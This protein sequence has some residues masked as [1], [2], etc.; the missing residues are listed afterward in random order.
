[1]RLKLRI[2][3]G[4]YSIARATAGSKTCSRTS[5]VVG[6]GYAGCLPA[7]DMGTKVVEVACW[8]RFASLIG[9]LAADPRTD[10]LYRGVSHRSHVLIPKIGRPEARRDPLDGRCLPHSTEAERAALEVF[11][12]RALPHLGRVPANDLEWLA[13][14]QHHGAPTRLLDWTE[15][16]LVAAFFALEMAGVDDR[17]AIFVL[18]RPPPVTAQDAENPFVLQGVKSYDPPHIASRISAQRGVFTVQGD[19]T[20]LAELEGLEQWVL[21]DGAERFRMR[22]IVDRIGFNR[23]TIYP[24]LQG[25]AEHVGWMYKWGIDLG[26]T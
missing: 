19:P 17:P 12:R 22:Q 2:R 5:P 9:G 10:R 13:V 18:D 23:A 4:A 16:P 25:L 14:A 8:D 11:K 21:P 20:S 26:G 1:L 3:R 6:C 24:D 7:P 15:S